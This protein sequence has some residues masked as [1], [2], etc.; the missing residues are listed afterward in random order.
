MKIT[1]KGDYALKVIL[2]LALNYP[3]KLLTIHE[4]SDRLD[5]PYKFL[6]Q[7]LLVLKKGGFVSSKRGKIGGYFL[8]KPPQKIKLGD[9]VRFID[10][11]IEPISCVAEN[12]KGCDDVYNCVFR[13]IWQRI[14]SFTSEILDNI[15]FEDLA[16]N[17]K[18][19]KDVLIYQI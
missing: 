17:V 7:I 14:A 9:I 1:Y 3:N 10:G 15:T 8:M 11:P 13:N 16:N 4:L 2:E 5:I 6:E 19:H 18:K 12:Y